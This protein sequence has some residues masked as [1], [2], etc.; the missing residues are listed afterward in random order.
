MKILYLTTARHPDDY[1]QLLTER[2]TAPNPSNQ[3]FHTKLIGILSSSFD[4]R[5]YS[6]RPMSSGVILS[7]S[8]KGIYYY[9]SYLNVPG[10]KRLLLL[11]SLIKEAQAFKPD[12]VFV[13]AMNVTLLK[14]A[15]RLKRESGVKVIALLTDNPINLTGAKKSYTEDVFKLSSLVDGYIA[16]TEGLA[17]LYN[18]AQKPFIVIPGFIDLPPNPQPREDFVF[19]GGALY[20]RYGVDKLI[21]S[22]LDETLP[23]KLLIAGHGPLAED[24]RSLHSKNIEFLGHITPERSMAYALRAKININ[25]RPIDEQ[26]DLYSV[27]SKVLDYINSGT[28][29]I[30]TRNNEIYNLVGD[31]LYWL[32]DNRPES[33]KEAINDILSNYPMW[34]AKANVAQNDLQAVLNHKQQLTNIKELI[35]KVG[36]DHESPL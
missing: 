31:N 20:P 27:P 13:D 29:T 1:N 34:E 16:L 14:L 5:V 8:R 21:T 26:I 3:N 28:I 30:S 7:S 2:K 10:L 32:D 25:P 22:F 4:V 19:F 35:K 24:L 6:T 12:V 18:I 11:A 17:R 33:I 36:V 23:L 9:P 15:R